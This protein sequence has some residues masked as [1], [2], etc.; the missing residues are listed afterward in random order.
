M[1]TSGF[2]MVS[3]GFLT[4]SHGFLMVSGGFLAFSP[5]VLMGSCGLLAF[6]PG[7]RMVSG[8]FLTCSVGFLMLSGGVFA[9]SCCLPMAPGEIFM[10]IKPVKRRKL[11]G[12]HI[13]KQKLRKK[14]GNS[15]NR[16]VDI[17]ERWANQ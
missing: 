14:N 6:S 12:V 13:R 4:C 15:A 10:A 17:N 8:G 5:G 1:K 3:G 2:P 16:N 7:F 11:R 9:F